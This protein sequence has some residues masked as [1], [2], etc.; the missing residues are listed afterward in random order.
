MKAPENTYSIKKNGSLDEIRQQSHDRSQ[1][2]GVVLSKLHRRLSK[3]FDQ[4]AVREENVSR[5][6]RAS[7]LLEIYVAVYK[8][9]RQTV[10]FL[11]GYATLPTARRTTLAPS[12]ASVKP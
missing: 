9:Q 4:P 6:V 12:I 5:S 11:K 3:S 10:V 1:N 8:D 7:C 2:F